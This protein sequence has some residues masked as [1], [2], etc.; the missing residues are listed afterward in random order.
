MRLSVKYEA[1][2][3]CLLTYYVNPNGNNTEIHLFGSI[4]SKERKENG[5]LR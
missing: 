2:E 3:N 1:P 4:P 5:C